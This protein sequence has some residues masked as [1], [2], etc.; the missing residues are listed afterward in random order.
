[1]ALILIY[2]KFSK[3]LNVGVSLLWNVFM[4]LTWKLVPF[5]RMVAL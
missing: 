5:P 3:N 2:L 1:M 4:D